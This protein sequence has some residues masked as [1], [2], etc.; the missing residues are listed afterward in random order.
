MHI[1][2]TALQELNDTFNLWLDALEHYSFAQLCIKPSPTSWSLGQV[3]MHLLRETAHFIA[4]AKVCASTSDHAHEETSPEAHVIFSN[5]SL[6][7]E[8]IEGPPSNA[9]V[10]QPV[11][12]EY[13]LKAL[14]DL[15]NEANRVGKLIS[16]NA[17]QGKSEHPGLKYFNALEWLQFAEIHCRH[18]LRQKKRIDEFLS[19]NKS[20]YEKQFPER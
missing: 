16:E 12:K 10:P 6:G 9:N 15:Q 17:F 13:L 3:Y 18:H 14:T 5:N 11:S 19:L 2:K 20:K 1:R 8:L 7:D 4:Q